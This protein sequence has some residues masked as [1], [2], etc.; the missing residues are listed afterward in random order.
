MV[1]F[2]LRVIKKSVEAVVVV[3]VMVGIFNFIRTPGDFI[4]KL[5]GSYVL[6]ANQGGEIVHAGKDLF[7]SQSERVVQNVGREILKKAKDRESDQLTEISR[8]GSWRR[9]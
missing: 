3:T 7:A 6:T 2:V 8:S 4:D 1:D 9:E 5:K